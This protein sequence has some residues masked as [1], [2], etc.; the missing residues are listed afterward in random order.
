[1]PKMRDTIGKAKKF[2][3]EDYFLNMAGVGFG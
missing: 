3:F 2:F 1:M